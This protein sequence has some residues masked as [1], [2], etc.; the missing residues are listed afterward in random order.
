MTIHA[1]P[2]GPQ[3]VVPC[4][5]RRTL[6]L[7]PGALTT[8]DPKVVTCPGRDRGGYRTHGDRGPGPGVIYSMGIVGDLAKLEPPIVI[9]VSS[10]TDET[11]T[12]CRFCE[13]VMEGSVIDWDDSITVHNGPEPHK[14]TC[15]WARAVQVVGP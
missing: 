7:G 8:D 13:A 11:A 12:I 15:V 1:R 6:E 14:P 2:E 4:C 5:G 3:D 10:I 9:S